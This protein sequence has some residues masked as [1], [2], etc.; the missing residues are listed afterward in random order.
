MNKEEL[1][2]AL[3]PISEGLFGKQ[4]TTLQF[5]K[6]HY[7]IR[8]IDMMLEDLVQ[9]DDISWGKYAFSREPLN[10]KFNDEQRRELTLKANACG[11]E[12]AH[13]YRNEYG[14]QDPESLATKM[15]IK[16]QYPEMPQNA[17]RVL[18]AEFKNPNNVYIYTDAVKKA[19]ETIGDSDARNIL[20][21][22]LNIS[23]LLLA[24]EL[25]HF[26][27]NQNAH[28]IFTR[29]EKV[30]LWAPKP[31][32]NR[33]GIDVLGEI[34]AM[35]FAKELTGISYSPYVMDVFL[36]YGYNPEEASGLY[37]EIMEYAGKTPRL[38]EDAGTSSEQNDTKADEA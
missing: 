27:E 3:K 33:S 32:H 36:V 5:E 1:K 4:R 17:E 31:L 28:K 14:E 7:V 35:A 6:P 21:Y 38:P 13:R 29:T 8:P 19:T 26:V 9:I 34:A 30:E 15:G 18:F 25:F 20:G 16:V 12:Y 10:G 23:R 22:N 2:K 37:E 24:H 11:L